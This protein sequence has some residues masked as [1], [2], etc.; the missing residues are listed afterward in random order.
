MCLL[1][2]PAFTRAILAQTLQDHSKS[3]RAALDAGDLKAAL[4][5]LKATRQADASGFTL[6]NY[7]YL[8]ARLLEKAGDAAASASGYQAVVARHSLLSKYALW[9]LAQ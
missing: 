1:V 9:H 4:A 2:L 5:E 7:D 6:N 3:I 8:L